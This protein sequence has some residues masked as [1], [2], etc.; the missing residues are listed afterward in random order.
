MPV[1]HQPRVAWDAARLVV[2]AVRDED[3]FRW[4]SAAVG[5]LLG[6]TVEDALEVTR[7]RLLWA[8]HQASIEAGRWRVRLEDALRDRPEVAGELHSLTV[9]A[10]GL[11]RTRSAAPAS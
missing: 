6:P 4:F 8:E 7:H 10:A 3:V 11:L 5:D 1:I 9:I 2:D